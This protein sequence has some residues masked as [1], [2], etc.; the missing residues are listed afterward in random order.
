MFSIIRYNYASLLICY[1]ILAF[2]GWIKF[3]IKEAVVLEK[4]YHCLVVSFTFTHSYVS[5][6]LL[7]IF[8]FINWR[9]QKRWQFILKQ[10]VQFSAP[11]M[12]LFL[13]EN[14]MSFLLYSKSRSPVI[15][16]ITNAFIPPPFIL[17][18]AKY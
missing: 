16:S 10:L 5:T 11:F 13:W 4:D 1:I 6:Q 14:T 2:Q 9:E 17:S 8:S 12:T 18:L 7:W 15:V 3:I